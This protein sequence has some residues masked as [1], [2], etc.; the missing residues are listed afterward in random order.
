VAP[1]LSCPS[2]HTTNVRLL[3]QV[4]SRGHSPDFYRC[5]SCGH[6]WSVGKAP[7]NESQREKQGTG[8]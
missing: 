7:V 8:T 4:T 6:V 2:C 3:S 5:E 1:E